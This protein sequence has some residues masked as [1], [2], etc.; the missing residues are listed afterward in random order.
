MIAIE[1]E[2]KNVGDPGILVITTI[3]SS[4]LLL[5]KQNHL[6]P[7]IYNHVPILVA[8]FPKWTLV[9][10]VVV[11]VRPTRTVILRET[12]AGRPIRIIVT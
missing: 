3:M 6:Y 8:E 10:I 7:P 12:I 4:S 5:I 1:H 2:E 11:C 9:A